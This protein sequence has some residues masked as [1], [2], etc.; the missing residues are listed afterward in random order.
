MKQPRRTS[1]MLPLSQK[2]VAFVFG[3]ENGAVSEKLVSEAAREAYQKSYTH[4][5]VIGFAIQPNA[6]DLIEHSAEVTGVPATYVQAT[7]DSDD[8]RPFEEHAFQ[9]DLQC[10]R[11]ARNHS[12]PGRTSKKRSNIRLS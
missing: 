12:S 7:P 5:Y 2:P 11:P 9:P 8:G 6:R 3:P 10:L 4:L 1:S